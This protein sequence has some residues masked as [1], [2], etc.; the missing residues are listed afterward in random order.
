M[1]QGIAICSRASSPSQVF[2][3]GHV[4]CFSSIDLEKLSRNVLFPKAIMRALVGT[5][6]HAS[7]NTFH[8]ASNTL[9]FSP[10]LSK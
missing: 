6:V 4:Q 7:S 3:T 8:S 2:P 10:R 9:T 1:T 5:R